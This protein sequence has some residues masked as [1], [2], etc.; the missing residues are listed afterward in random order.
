[1]HKPEEISYSQRRNE[2]RNPPKKETII[3]PITYN[4]KLFVDFDVVICIPSHNR[5]FKVRRLI[6]Q[7][8][9]QSTNYSFKIILLN[10]GSID[11]NY[12]LLKEEFPEL[13][14]IKNNTANGK[15][16]HWYCYNQMWEYLKKITS[17]CVLQMDDDFIICDNFL[18]TILD[19]F[20][21]KKMENG[22][23]MAIAPHLWSFNIKSDCEKWWNNNY[24]IDGIGLIDYD[25]INII[26]YELK[27]VDEK[28]VIK[29][30][31][32][33]GA[34]TQI[35]N[36]IK[37][38]NGIVYRPDNSLVYHDALNDSKL[39]GDFRVN[40]KHEIYTQKFID[41]II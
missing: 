13:I 19:L 3:E 1:M 40:G 17:H 22:N 2:R 14:Y 33:A 5:Y 24:S 32:A 41:E 8:Y 4:K 23:I 27:K 25:I 11:N 38:N 26:N 39:H 31:V 29:T 9:E 6:K 7:F 18:N 12:K 35:S 36:A 20:F 15:V 30:G 21:E 34:W 16:L 10:D 28:V 37:N